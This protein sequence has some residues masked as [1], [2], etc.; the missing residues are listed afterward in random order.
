MP[1]NKVLLE[2]IISKKFVSVQSKIIDR[3][4]LKTGNVIGLL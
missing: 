3:R 2:P 1:A 4:G